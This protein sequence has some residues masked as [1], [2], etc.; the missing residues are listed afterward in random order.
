MRLQLAEKAADAAENLPPTGGP[1]LQ[2]AEL[3]MRGY[4]RNVEAYVVANAKDG[5]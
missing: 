2:V 5:I 1:L 4:A 3:T